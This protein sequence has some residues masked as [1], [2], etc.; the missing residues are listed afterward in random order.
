[1][2]KLLLSSVILLALSACNKEPADIGTVPED[3]D[4]NAAIES[5]PQE[6]GTDSVQL[7]D[8]LYKSVVAND[9]T[10]INRLIQQGANVNYSYEYQYMNG[11]HL[12]EGQENFP[13]EKLVYS[14]AEGGDCSDITLLIDACD[15]GNPELVRTLLKAGANIE[16]RDSYG[17]TPLMHASR[18]GDT[19]IASLLLQ[20]G[21][22]IN[23][24]SADGSTALM[25][26]T[27]YED[28]PSIAKNR[29]QIVELLLQ[30]GADVNAPDGQGMTVLTNAILQ[31]YNEIV[32]ILLR[33]GADVNAKDKY[34]NTP[35]KLAQKAGYTKIVELLKQAGA[36]E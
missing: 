31:G 1:M 12:A 34:G 4:L 26:T 11:T 3:Y 23:A 36:K 17:H 21:A 7:Q 20:E 9:I 22:N 19:E 10:N 2:R 8:E 18:W 14:D 29:I 32:P 27:Y 16:G 5:L 33:A 6:K 13:V 28:N 25:M 24:E 35:L 15:R 30:A